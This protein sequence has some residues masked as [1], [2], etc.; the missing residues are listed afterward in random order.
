[1]NIGTHETAERT[2]G[3]QAS[4]RIIRHQDGWAIDH[5]G[6]VMG[7]YSTKEAAFESAAGA[8]SNS[9]KEGF[10]VVIEVPQRLPGEAAIGGKAM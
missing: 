7:S 6:K 2:M 1:M 4:Y 10:G 3:Q 8:A 9:I 5:D